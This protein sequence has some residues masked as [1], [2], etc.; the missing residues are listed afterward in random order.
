MLFPKQLIS[1]EILEKWKEYY[2]LKFTFKKLFLR[3]LFFWLLFIAITAGLFLSFWFLRFGKNIDMK[4]FLALS[5]LLILDT[6]F[7][8]SN[9]YHHMRIYNIASK[10]GDKQKM[11]KSISSISRYSGPEII[12]S[13]I[14]SYKKKLL[15]NNK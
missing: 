12:N 13:K 11:I 9:T 14:E 5:C 15:K 7:V 3:F 1:E 4:F 10:N 8:C 6:I 2:V